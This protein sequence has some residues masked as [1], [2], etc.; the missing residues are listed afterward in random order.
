MD[1][2]W[3]P[4]IFALAAMRVDL[5]SVAPSDADPYCFDRPMRIATS[6]NEKIL[7]DTQDYKDTRLLS[8]LGMS[9]EWS[10]LDLDQFSDPNITLSRWFDSS[11]DINCMHLFTA[12]GHTLG[13]PQNNWMITQYINI[14]DS[15]VDRVTL[16]ATFTVSSCASCPTSFRVFIL[17]TDT[18]NETLRNDIS[19][20]TFTGI[21]LFHLSESSQ[22]ISSA[23]HGIDISS[24]GF[25]LAIVDDGSCVVM[26]RLVIYYNICPGQVNN[27]IIYPETVAPTDTI[28]IERMVTGS[29]IDNASPTSDLQLTCR[30]SGLW[31]TNTKSCTCNP[32]YEFINTYCKACSI[33]TYKP[34]QGDERCQ[35]CPV[36][37]HS[38][39]NSSTG[40]PCLSGYYRASFEGVD[41]PCTAPPSPPL[42]LCNT[43][44]TSTNFTIKWTQPNDNGGR[45][46]F[47]IVNI[48]GGIS[49]NVS[50]TTY[51]FNNLQPST[52]YIVKVTSTNGVSDQ[53]SINDINRTISIT[54]T[55]LSSPPTKPNNINLMPSTSGDVSLLTWDEPDNLYGT[56]REYRIL[57]SNVSDVTTAQVVATI[58]NRTFELS[59]L[60]IETGTYY[61]W[62]QAV[63]EFGPG[64]ISTSF[65]TYR[66]TASTPSPTSIDILPAVIGAIGGIFLLI[67]IPIIVVVIIL[68]IMV[69]MKS[70]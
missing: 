22:T 47:Y 57:L 28:N 50:D 37:S 24:S 26:S 39:T 60:D 69:R 49:V 62:V 13:L 21:R 52:T 44:L 3:I 42:Q 5:Q 9:L 16:N 41:D 54:I 40:C 63:T 10:S 59:G 56:L 2:K 64:E 11:Q 1:I 14:S 61:I 4:L 35:G 32:G 38:S 66:H 8:A 70:K 20:Y 7:L 27:S 19:S 58:T 15:N 45:L 18:V 67:L 33:G 55:T 43:S 17:Q 46:V 6:S 31:V 53:D 48:T 25:Y 12:C 34:V 29:C 68:I 65:A 36:N 30:L 23:S 51:T